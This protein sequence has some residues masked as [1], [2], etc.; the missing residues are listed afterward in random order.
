MRS[1]R[2][3][4]DAIAAVEQACQISVML[5]SIHMPGISIVLVFALGSC[6]QV[7]KASLSTSEVL[8]CKQRGGAESR[9]P[10]GYPM[11]M[12][13]YADAGK[14]DCLGRCLSEATDDTAAIQVGMQ[15]A[16]RCES[17]VDSLGCYAR[18]DKG[19]LAEPYYCIE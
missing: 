18:V 15:V 8:Q 11:C 13:P 4:H 16:G 3:G 1:R 6:T 9:T 19:L 5:P 10:F 17:K 14:A 2:S 12:V 7:T